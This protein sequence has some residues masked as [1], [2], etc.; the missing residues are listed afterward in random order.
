MI[1]SFFLKDNIPC[2]VVGQ[3]DVEAPLFD[4]DTISGVIPT[5]FAE[6]PG[7][8]DIAFSTDRLNTR[9]DVEQLQRHLFQPE[10][11]NIHFSP[12]YTK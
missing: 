4:D 10:V 6:E 8:A 7:V 2:I 9:K 11:Y 12:L 5:L 1:T 3:W